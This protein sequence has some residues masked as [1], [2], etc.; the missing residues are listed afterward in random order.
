M[1]IILSPVASNKKTAIALSGLVLTI[2]DVE[3]DLSAIPEGGQAEPE[4]DSHFIGIVTR[5][6]VTIKYEY[7]SSKAEPS[8]STDWADY[9][10]DIDDG[11]VPCPIQW[12]PIEQEIEQEMEVEQ[13]V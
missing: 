11:E 2:D 13:D 1:K 5:E 12:L 10:F 4:E 7:D 6:S 9:T 3:Y 8:Q